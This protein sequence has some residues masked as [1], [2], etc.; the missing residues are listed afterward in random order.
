MKICIK[1]QNYEKNKKSRRIFQFFSEFYKKFAELFSAVFLKKAAMNKGLMVVRQ[2]GKIRDGAEGSGLFIIGAEYHP[3]Y[4]RVYNSAGAHGTG[5][6]GHVHIALPQPPASQ[7]T[8]GVVYCLKLGVKESVFAQLTP[9]PA[10]AHDPAVANYHSPHGHLILQSGDTSQ[11]KGAEHIFFIKL[12][13]KI[14]P[15]IVIN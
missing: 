3:G 8:A 13:H 9:V 4:S 1:P 7:S 6:K 10:L 15:P 5:L 14:Y 12:I 11:L 2:G